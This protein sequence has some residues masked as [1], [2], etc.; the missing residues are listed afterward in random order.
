MSHIRVVCPH[1][2]LT[3]DIPPEKVPDRP[4]QVTC[5]RCKQ[6]FGF[7]KPV[8]STPAGPSETAPPVTP[9][10]SGPPVPPP[11]PPRIPPPPAEP[12]P[13]TPPPPRPPSAPAPPPPSPRLPAAGSGEL[14]TIEELFRTTWEAYKERL[15]TLVGIF[16]L[17]LAVAFLPVGII[18]AAA[19]F[20]PKETLSPT[21]APVIALVVL[22][23]LAGFIAF[24]GGLAALTA[25]VLD[26]SLGIRGAF[27]EGRKVWL[28]F[29]WVTS[30]YGFIVGGGML[31]LFI[32]G[33][34]FATWFFAAPYI[35]VAGEARGME[36]LLR[37]R[38]LVR[39][40]FFEVFI[41]LFLIW[42]VSG[43]AGAIPFIGPFLSLLAAPLVMLFHAHLFR[44]LEDA[45]GDVS[46]P[47]GFGDKARWVAAGLAGYLLV[48]ALLIAMLGGAFFSSLLPALRE[49]KGME[50][51]RRVITIPP[52]S[53]GMPAM[54]SAPGSP[55]VGA[56]PG[57]APTTTPSIEITTPGAGGGAP[58]GQL[59]ET[60]VSVFIYAVNCPGTIRVNGQEFEVIKEVPD[61]QYN[62]N[63][64]GKH[65]RAGSNTI[66]F[67]VTPRTEA[68][69]TLKPEI[70]MRVS[71]FGSGGKTVH[72]EWRLSDSDGWQRSVTVEIPAGGSK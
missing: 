60:D 44:D 21:S 13:P 64:F 72:G 7:T 37:S 47:C 55:Q 10:P 62:I 28:P 14:M 63:A 69:R 30:L 15:L 31:L 35:T 11:E 26:S 40:R 61:M 24:F 5:P 42:A 36:A 27:A 51:G 17:A 32:P 3:R 43:V 50:P 59:R 53:G 38:A 2:A 57:S 23:V 67:D 56:P 39:G 12:V 33:M 29:V 22:A 66:E 52:P 58:A 8:S 54:P 41:R 34:I 1:C 45:A 70:H 16:L 46:Y 18:A 49:L 4:V 20:L 65:F 19:T 68:G 71:A 6:T 25:A 9:E 48:P